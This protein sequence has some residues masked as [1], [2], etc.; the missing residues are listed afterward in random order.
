MELV[1]GKTGV[2]R[3]ISKF[4]L[5]G[6]LV[7][8]FAKAILTLLAVAFV[9][10]LVFL[11]TRALYLGRFRWLAVVLLATTV[12][13]FRSARWILLRL[14]HCAKSTWALLGPTLATGCS[15]AWEWALCFV[16][17]GRLAWQTF[18]CFSRKI[19]QLGIRLPVLGCQSVARAAKF[20]FIK[21]R[22][23][24]RDWRNPDRGC[25]RRAR[26]R[27]RAQSSQSR[28]SHFFP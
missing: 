24:A 11:F 7:V 13:L 21:I 1:H 26:G 6:I 10:L 22:N 9:G 25:E 2:I 4:I 27:A 5:L 15:T 18:F 16:R 20:V 8:M 19:T 12:H 14:S 17:C 23:G 3:L 28:G